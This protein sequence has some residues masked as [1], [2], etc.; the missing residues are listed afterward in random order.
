[1]GGRAWKYW[2]A[3]GPVFTMQAIISVSHAHTAT[4]IFYLF[5]TPPIRALNTIRVSLTGSRALVLGI[6]SKPL[7]VVFG[8]VFEIARPIDS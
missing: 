3:S 7:Y 2:P 4:R 5:L 6:K 8:R 1:M